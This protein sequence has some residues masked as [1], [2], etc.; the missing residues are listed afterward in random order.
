[1]PV[2]W[3]DVQI[4]PIDTTFFSFKS[5]RDTS[6]FEYCVDTT[7]GSILGKKGIKTTT[8]K[9]VF[10]NYQND[11][12]FF[13]SKAVLNEI[14][15]LFIYPDNSYI[16]AKM[17]GLITDSIFHTFDTIKVF[18]LQA[19]DAL[20]NNIANPYNNKQI[21]LSKNNGFVQ[22]FD[23]YLFPNDN[24][25]YTLAGENWPDVGNHNIDYRQV[26]DFQPGDEFHIDYADVNNLQ[27]ASSTYTKTIKKCLS[28]TDDHC[29]NSIAYLWEICKKTEIY[30]NDF[31]VLTT[32]FQI[33][34]ITDTIRFAI[35]NFSRFDHISSEYFIDSALTNL[36][37]NILTTTSTY[38]QRTVKSLLSFQY[39]S[40]GSCWSE[41]I[42]DPGPVSYD[43]IQG[44]GGPY[45]YSTPWIFGNYLKNALVY[46]KKGNEI[47]GTP[48]AADCNALSIEE[49][50]E[51]D[52][53]TVYPNP[54]N[55][56]VNFA[57]EKFP[58]TNE[59]S[60][61]I[62]D[63]TGKNIFSI[64]S[65]KTLTT[66]NTEDLTTGIYFYRISEKGQVLKSDKFLVLR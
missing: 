51:N 28:R 5:V 39:W 7:G 8:N 43:Y 24:Q 21:T 36:I 22:L 50:K 55:Q 41:A 18:D 46:F 23:F 45:Y 64:L 27:G 40:S 66:L 32:E 63:F 34:T 49:I 57:V 48:L 19:K 25:T 37:P 62:Y 53:V 4:T 30:S 58:L 6:G 35:L 2:R 1:M 56:E 33:D 65:S 11:S 47:W 42:A 54:A 20:G 13:F 60:I 9:V 31:G 10:I 14:W 52:L 29:A 26:Y 15:P 38:N 12:I 16:E 61:E 3:D 17:T 44:C 59:V